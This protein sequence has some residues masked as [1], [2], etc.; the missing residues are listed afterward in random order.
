MT[1]PCRTF[2]IHGGGEPIPE[3]LLGRAT[4][5]YATGRIAFVRP[6]QLVVKLTRFR[7]SGMKLD[8][9]AAAGWLGLLA[10][11]SL[12]R[13]IELNSAVAGSAVRPCQHVRWNHR[14][15]LFGR[16]RAGAGVFPG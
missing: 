16:S 10:R 11:Q 7:L 14:A 5:W 12:V 13:A 3:T 2:P 15:E 6:N 4:Q 8:D 9:G 1:G